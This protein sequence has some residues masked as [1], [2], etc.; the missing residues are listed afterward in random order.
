MAASGC[1]SEAPQVE[2]PPL[3]EPPPPMEITPL[4]IP[5]NPNDD[6]CNA[7]ARSENGYI[8]CFREFENT[9][10]EDRE[11]IKKRAAYKACLD[12]GYPKGE[13]PEGALIGFQCKGDNSNPGGLTLGDVIATPQSAASPA[14]DQGAA[15]APK[16]AQ[17][18]TNE[19]Q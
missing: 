1:R 6:F 14:P 7:C 12:A 8:S 2:C 11:E 3:P 4:R 9:R 18:K 13:C 15:T 5:R 19:N 10:G 17:N 16:P